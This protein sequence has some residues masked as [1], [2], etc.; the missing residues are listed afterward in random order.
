MAKKCKIPLS[1]DRSLVASHLLAQRRVAIK[2][3][4]EVRTTIVVM[5]PGDEKEEEV[6]PPSP[7]ANPQLTQ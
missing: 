4:N 7:T 5:S 6:K 3:A 2:L 1:H